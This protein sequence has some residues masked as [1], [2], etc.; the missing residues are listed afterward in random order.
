[1]VDDAQGGVMNEVSTR[2]IRRLLGLFKAPGVCG[3]CGADPAKGKY[4]AAASFQQWS[5]AED[6]VTIIEKLM[7]YST[8]PKPN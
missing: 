2:A 5:D 3:N 1:M 7:R 8:E 6:E 4:S